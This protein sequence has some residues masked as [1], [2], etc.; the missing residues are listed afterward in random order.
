M[1][2]YGRYDPRNKKNGRNKIRSLNRDIRIHETSK[3]EKHKSWMRE[4]SD[5]DL[6]THGMTTPGDLDYEV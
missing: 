4:D 5:E 6:Y 3:P 2:K 1:A